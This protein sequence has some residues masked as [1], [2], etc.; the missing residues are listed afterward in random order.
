MKIVIAAPRKSGNVQLRCLLAAAYGL[1]AVGSRDNP[2]EANDEAVAAWMDELPDGS[3]VHTGFAFTPRLATLAAEHDVTFVAIVRHPYDLFV[4]NFEIA[5]RRAGSEKAAEG[6]F[7]A[8]VQLGERALDD[9]EVLAYLDDG[10]AREIAWLRG[11]QESGYPIVRF[12]DLDVDE[13]AALHALANALGPL[14][15]EQV[16]KAVDACAAPPVYRARPERGRRMPAAP[17][18]AWRDRLSE[19]HLTILRDRYGE[20]IRQLRYEVY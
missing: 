6:R 2:D 15:P 12:E 11:W 4:S 20:D 9:P 8:L 3:I 19:A 17:A 1:E 16:A 5:Q 18:G 7:G 10:F 13:T 14:T